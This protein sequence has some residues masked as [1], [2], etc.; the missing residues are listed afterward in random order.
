[1]PKEAKK[2]FLGDPYS[3]LNAAK[4]LVETSCKPGG[5]GPKGCFHALEK[6]EE[7]LKVAKAE[8]KDDQDFYAALREEVRSCTSLIPDKPTYVT[9]AKAFED[10]RRTKVKYRC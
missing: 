1:M 2:V 3:Y 4:S 10:F 7:A 5:E 8:K 6:I 9:V